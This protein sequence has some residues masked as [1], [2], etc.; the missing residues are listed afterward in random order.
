MIHKEDKRALRLRGN[1]LSIFGFPLSLLVHFSLCKSFQFVGTALAVNC[2]KHF[3][4][5][6]PPTKQVFGKALQK[7]TFG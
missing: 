1:K 6:V 2:S 4:T 7:T 5:K 3:G